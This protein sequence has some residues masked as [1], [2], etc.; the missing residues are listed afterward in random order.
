M[1]DDKVFTAID[2]LFIWVWWVILKGAAWT[3]SQAA[4]VIGLLLVGVVLGF[5]Q[6]LVLRNFITRTRAWV[7]VTGIVLGIALPSSMF[8]FMMVSEEQAIPVG[9]VTGA[10]LG[11]AQRMVLYSHSPTARWWTPFSIVAMTAG[12][13]LGMHVFYGFFE[14][15]GTVLHNALV[16]SIIGTV[17]GAITGVALVILLRDIQ[18][19]AH[20]EDV[21]DVEDDQDV[22]DVEETEAPN[23]GN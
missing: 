10:C 21:E 14:G 1:K 2:W 23:G 5:A 18:A 8:L 16:G 4:G 13:S 22:E 17:Y 12:F 20:D 11:F 9:A 19:H 6:R 15:V 7:I 3:L